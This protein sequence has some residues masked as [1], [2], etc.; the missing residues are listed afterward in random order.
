LRD[1]S[2]AGA[3]GMRFLFALI[4]GYTDIRFSGD[5]NFVN[6]IFGQSL[7]LIESNG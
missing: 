6:Q 7:L 3:G 4:V 1:S 5:N 2:E